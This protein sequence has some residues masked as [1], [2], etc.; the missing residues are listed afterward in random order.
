[1]DEGSSPGVGYTRLASTL[2]GGGS[3]L[4][5]GAK[6]ASFVRLLLL[7]CFI[8][9]DVVQTRFRRFPAQEVRGKVCFLPDGCPE[10]K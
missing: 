7:E 8:I 4:S 3:V 5:P 9:V 1:M 6:G 2:F 10:Q